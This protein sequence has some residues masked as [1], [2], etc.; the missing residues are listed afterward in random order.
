MTELKNQ[1]K[2]DYKLQILTFIQ[3]INELPIELIIEQLNNFDMFLITDTSSKPG[4]VLDEL[5]ILKT[6]GNGLCWINAI[7]VTIFGK[8]YL[9]VSEL[10]LW[11][12]SLIATFGL[13]DNF[14]PIL[15]LY[16]YKINLD[17]LSEFDL[18]KF[19]NSN[20]Y[21]MFVLSF[22]ILKFAV[23][24]YDNFKLNKI[25]K[26]CPLE[27]AIAFNPKKNKIYAIDGQLRN[28]IM[29]IIGIEKV[30]IFQNK[31][32]PKH[33]RYTNKD[34]NLSAIDYEGEYAGFEIEA[35][36]NLNCSGTLGEILLF[37]HNSEHYDAVFNTNTFQTCLALSDQYEIL[38]KFI[39]I[40]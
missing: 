13:D 6:Y 24:N 37:T 10:E 40:D 18:I 32:E 36:H 31:V 28:F 15:N 5:I 3:S 29:A 17:G 16:S 22:N 25:N 39:T 9:N 12:Q 7:L 26:I 19:L 1:D 2:I 34:L 33:R 14:I 11:I 27:T 30:V 20:K 4:Y 8:F 21:L 35:F 23:L 38:P